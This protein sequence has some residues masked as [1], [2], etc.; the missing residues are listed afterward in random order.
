MRASIDGANVIG[1]ALAGILV[2]A[3]ALSRG[4]GRPGR[5]VRDLLI[6]SGIIAGL[7]VGFAQWQERQSVA[8]TGG[9]QL[10]MAA[11]AEATPRDVS[12]SATI[13]KGPDGHFWTEARVN[14]RTQRF[15]VDTGA[16]YVALPL[17]DAKRLG[18]SPRKDEFTAQVQTANGMASAAPVVLRDIRISG[19]TLR[20]VDAVVLSDG[21]DTALLGMSFLNRLESFEAKADSL[22]LKS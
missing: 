6:W 4:E 14:G 18:V 22:R 16:S 8:P 15:M 20:D 13:K 17:K 5:M 3:G 7:A 2:G 11:P 9:E 10:T 21:L 12:G 1:L 19:V